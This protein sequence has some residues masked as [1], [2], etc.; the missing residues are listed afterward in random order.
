MYITLRLKKFRSYTALMLVFLL[1]V[2][3]VLYD[4]S[5]TVNASA[6]LDGPV[7]IIDAGHGGEDGGAVSASGVIES[8]INLEIALRLDAI[9]GLYGQRTA[10]TRETEE[11]DYPED[12]VTIAQKKKADQHARVE[13][14]NSLPDAVLISIHQNFFPD[15]RPSG[16]QVLYGAG[17]E[18]EKLGTLTHELLCTSLCPDNR[19]VAA[20]ISES[21]YLMKK[22]Q[23][24]AILVECG[25]LSNAAET[26]LLLTDNYQIKLSA[27]LMASYMQYRSPADRMDT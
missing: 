1:A 14:I 11:I 2:W 21:I 27:V 7:L 26:E 24:T 8:G 9:A 25:F 20:P 22:A 10:M 5:K 17:E 3:T 15:S 4:G 23:C 16:C 13:L 12:A 18:S 19:R 6:I